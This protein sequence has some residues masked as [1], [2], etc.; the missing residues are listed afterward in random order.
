[1]RRFIKGALR[2]VMAIALTACTAPRPPTSPAPA[3]SSTPSSESL[4]RVLSFVPSTWIEEHP[5]GVIGPMLFY[6][7]FRSMA[8]DLALPDVSGEDTREAKLPLLTGVVTQGL[9]ITPPPLNLLSA[10]AYSEWGW[11]LADLDAAADLPGRRAAVM[12]GDFS[13][14]RV[15]TALAT[16]GYSSST[17]GA[18]VLL[19]K[20]GNT[21]QVAVSAEVITIAASAGDLQVLLDQPSNVSR[22]LAG[23]PSAKSLLAAMP[24]FHGIFLASSGDLQAAPYPSGGYS[25]AWSLMAI[26]FRAESG[27][28]ALAISY[29]YPS[30]QEARRDVDLVRETL[31]RSPS[32]R[33]PSLTWS[34]LLTTTSVVAQ[35]PLVIA[36]GTTQGES[37]I[38]NSVYAR[39]MYGL[40]PARPPA[41]APN[42]L[43][44]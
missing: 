10:S 28:T 13:Q 43:S 8:R 9:D 42:A 30:D 19:T 37:L 11:D 18:F 21:L 5:P 17:S 29:V 34:D 36:Q 27:T 32:F 7:D 38:G 6:F 1:M 35:G 4:F 15:R 2:L 44:P 12:I 3:A 16:R 31:T 40:L 22:S 14:D 20:P 41:T 24:A 39:D 26:G 23:S 25:Y 33:N